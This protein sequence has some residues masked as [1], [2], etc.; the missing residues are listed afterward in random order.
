MTAKLAIYFRLGK[1][2]PAGNREFLRE[3][4][5]TLLQGC[6]TDLVNNTPIF[7]VWHMTKKMPTFDIASS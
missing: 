4:N 3:L 6:E 1:H 7:K 2:T 5:L